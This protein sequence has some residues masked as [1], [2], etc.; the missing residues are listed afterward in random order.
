MAYTQTKEQA[1]KLIDRMAPSQ[2]TA[3]VGLMESMLDPVSLAIA[4]APEDDE[5]ETEEERSAVAASK[6]WLE[7]HPGEGITQAE[8]LAEF[9]DPR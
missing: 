6:S 4:R 7:Q 1:H 3:F 2:V 8:M 5:P 9:S